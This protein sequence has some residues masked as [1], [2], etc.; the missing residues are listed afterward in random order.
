MAGELAPSAERRADEPQVPL[1]WQVVALSR[2]TLHACTHAATGTTGPSLLSP[3]RGGPG[4]DPAALLSSVQS[5]TAL[6]ARAS[7]AT[8]IHCRPAIDSQDLTGDEV[9][10]GACKK[11]TGSDNIFWHLLTLYRSCCRTFRYMCT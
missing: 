2:S 6:A 9:T 4:C 3:S 1:A 11:Y 7:V 8:S 5:S 10:L